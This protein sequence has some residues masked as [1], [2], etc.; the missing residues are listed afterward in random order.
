MFTNKQVLNT[1]SGCAVVLALDSVLN[2]KNINA[3]KTI[4]V[5][6]LLVLILKFLD[7]LINDYK[8]K[9]VNESNTNSKISDTDFDF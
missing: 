8:C 1:I 9:E 3:R 6:I 5:I 7:N 4:L 2:P